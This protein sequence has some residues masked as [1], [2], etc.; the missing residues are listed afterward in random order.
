MARMR[1]GD[2]FF[3]VVVEGP[4][5]K[6][7]LLVANSLGTNLRLWDAQIPELT[8][9]FKVIR[10][11]SRGHGLSDAPRSPYSIWRLGRDALA[12]L[13][14]LGV[15]KAHF[16]GLSMGGMVGLWLLANAGGR[17]D[18]AVL[19]NTAAVMPPP[20]HWNMRI[21]MARENG[22]AAIAPMVANLWFPKTFQDRE[23]QQ[24]ARI[25]TMLATTPAHGYAA[26]C[27]AIRDMDQRETVRSIVNP[28]LVIAGRQDQSTPPE[29]GKFIA[30]NIPGAKYLLLDAGHLS[31]L[32][33]PDAFTRAVVDFLSVVEKK[34][35]AKPAKQPAVAP[36]PAPVAA[37][38]AE[39]PAVKK[40]PAKKAATK[41][42][43][44]KKPAK[45][46]SR[47][48]TLKRKVAKKPAA[49]AAKKKAAPRS[50]ARK[51][52]KKSVSRAARKSRPAA[53]AKAKS[54][55]RS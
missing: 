39:K 51:P 15:E 12:I 1:V 35:A 27:A 9:H 11:D 6:P 23:P 43:T 30:D 3:N 14:A 45:K 53:K 21:R 20:D 44:K 4:D 52:A 47:K 29:R 54:K 40:R 46:A 17:I 48:T 7:A 36:P 22:M 37:P 50:A 5:D 28:V 49:K 33:A 2:D 13:D 26:C 16:L 38:A 19:A 8:R 55:A 25:Q 42:A 31:N 18:R 10:Y 41:K 24:V 32:E 34:A